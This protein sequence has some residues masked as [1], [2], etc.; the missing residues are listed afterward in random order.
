MPWPATHILTAEAAYPLFFHHL[1]HKAFIIGTCFPDIRYPAQLER[2]VT[3]I[4]QIS[5]SDIGQESAFRAGLLFHTYVDDYWNA[6]FRQFSDRLFTIIPHNQPTFH[7]I[8]SL[9]DLYLYDQLDH[10]EQIAS[11]FK[12]MDPEE[13]TFGADKGLVRLWHDTLGHYLGKPPVEDDLDMLAMSL[14]T[15]M[16]AEIRSIYP[17]YRE[18]PLLKEVLLGFYPAYLAHL[19]GLPDSNQKG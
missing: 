10:W 9:Q 16:V 11:C 14:P 17:R 7:T 4:H 18:I 8:K 15:E 3:H 19:A 12:T 13:L 1:D 2:E 6:Y 5:L